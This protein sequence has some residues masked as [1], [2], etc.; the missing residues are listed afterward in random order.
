MKVIKYN[1]VNQTV[2]DKAGHAL[3]E[4]MIF[5]VVMDWS[6]ENEA[7]AQQE[8]CG[9]EYIIEDDGRADTVKSPTKLDIIEAQ[10]VYTA[11]MTDTLLEV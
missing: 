11:M 9:G 3:C 8:A 4:D 2:H 10:I 1:L 7:I 6:E 5:P